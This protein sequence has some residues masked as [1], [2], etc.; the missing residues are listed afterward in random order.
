MRSDSRKWLLY[1]VQH[2][3]HHHQ[4]LRRRRHRHLPLI[5]QTCHSYFRCLALLCV[6]AACVA[7]TIQA[8]SLFYDFA[9]K[10]DLRS[11]THQIHYHFQR[12]KYKLYMMRLY[13][14]KCPIFRRSLSSFSRISHILMQS[15]HFLYGFCLWTI[16]K[17]NHKRNTFSE[18]WSN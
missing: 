18:L 15:I 3:H 8:R 6:L 5:I 13:H 14:H 12:F 11:C 16:K 7:V 9:C 17:F 4:R 1:S 10:T 2:E